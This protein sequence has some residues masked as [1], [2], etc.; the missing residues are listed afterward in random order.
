M[1]LLSAVRTLPAVGIHRDQHGYPED[2][3]VEGSLLGCRLD[4]VHSRRWVAAGSCWL[5]G[6]SFLGYRQQLR[7]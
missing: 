5:P 4:W 1:D 6:S 2:L 3:E 7:S